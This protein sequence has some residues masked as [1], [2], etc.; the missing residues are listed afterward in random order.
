MVGAAVWWMSA[1]DSG[2]QGRLIVVILSCCPGHLLVVTA[3]LKSRDGND[4][5]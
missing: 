1:G 3:A 2:M 4:R 5:R